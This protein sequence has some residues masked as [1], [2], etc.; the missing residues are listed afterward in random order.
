LNESLFKKKKIFNPI[1]KFMFQITLKTS[2][3]EIESTV[4]YNKTD[5]RTIRIMF[6]YHHKYLWIIK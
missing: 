4:D 2:F 5:G 1:N 3:L 6:E